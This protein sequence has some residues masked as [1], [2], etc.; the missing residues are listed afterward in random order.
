MI[1]NHTSQG[2]Y[3]R[4]IIIALGFTTMISFFLYLPALWSFFTK[5]DAIAVNFYSYGDAFE[6]ATFGNSA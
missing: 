2:S 1:E 6:N 3:S 4:K 5:S